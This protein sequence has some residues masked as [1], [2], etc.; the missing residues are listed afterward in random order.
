[1]PTSAFDGGERKVVVRG[2]SQAREY[3]WGVAGG[4]KH[5]LSSV[6]QP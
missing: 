2:Q 6:A 1:M 4:Q 5:D 3:Q